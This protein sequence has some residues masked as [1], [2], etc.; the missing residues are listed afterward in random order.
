MLPRLLQLLWVVPLAALLTPAAVEPS[1]RGGRRET[2]HVVWVGATPDQNRFLFSCPNGHWDYRPKT[3][4]WKIK[5]ANGNTTTDLGQLRPKTKVRVHF[6]TGDGE[7]Q[8]QGKN[9]RVAHATLVE[10]LPN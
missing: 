10:V 8:Y 7:T 5:L 6:H 2:G 1:Q 9:F 3:G 4:Q